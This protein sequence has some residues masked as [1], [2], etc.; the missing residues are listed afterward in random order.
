MVAAAEQG[1]PTV[2]TC[3]GHPSAMVAPI[4]VG[5]RLDPLDVPDF[6]AYLLTIPE[7]LE[8]E[9]DTMALR[10]GRLSDEATAQG[11]RPC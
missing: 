9:R 3:H 10:A 4:E 11:R 2:I 8:I 1:R 7:V 5:R 6:A